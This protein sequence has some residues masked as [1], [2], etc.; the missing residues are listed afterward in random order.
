MR[1]KLKKIDEYTHL[2]YGKVICVQHSGGT[3]SVTKV[4]LEGGAAITVHKTASDIVDIVNKRRSVKQLKS[5]E[6]NA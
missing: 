2:E 5:I 3:Q 6:E 4:Y 1:E